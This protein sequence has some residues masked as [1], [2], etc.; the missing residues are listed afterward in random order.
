M[1]T[2][3]KKILPK[4][5][6]AVVTGAKQF[7]LRK[8]E[9][10]IQVGDELE[11]IEW[12]GEPTGKVVRC[13]VTY[14]LRNCVEYGLMDGYCIV[15]ISTPTVDAVEVVRC[16]DCKWCEERQGRTGNVYN[17]C[18]YLNTWVDEDHFCSCGERREDGNT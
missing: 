4:Y 7:E 18:V 1:K 8:D 9:D 17:L 14:V 12:D 2:I 13:D 11:L 15:G 3:K 10:D 5:F 6:G 16:K